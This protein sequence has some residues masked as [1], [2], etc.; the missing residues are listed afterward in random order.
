MSRIFRISGSFMQ[1]GKW[2]KPNPSFSGKII[3]DEEG[4]FYGYCEELYD[5]ASDASRIQYIAGAFAE[6]NHRRRQGIA[7][8]KMSNDPSQDPLAYITLDLENPESGS[9]SELSTLG[10]FLRRGRTRIVVEEEAFLR[11]P[12]I[13]LEPNMALSIRAL[14][15]TI[16]SLKRYRAS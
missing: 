7:F 11:R 8:F 16:S 1:F 9:W 3:A 13:V 15:G 12:R 2:S 5:G 10:R 4:R 6:N 14:M